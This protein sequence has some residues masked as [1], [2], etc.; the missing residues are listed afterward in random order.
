MGHAAYRLAGNFGPLIPAIKD[1]KN[2]GF[3]DV[4]WMLDDSIKELTTLNVF[5]V[6]QSRFGHLELLTPVD[7]K[8]LY[9]GVMRKSILDMSKQIEEMFNLKVVERNVSVHELVNSAREGRLLEMFGAATHCSLQPI[10]RVVYKD[11]TMVLDQ[12]T[13]GEITGK[14]SELMLNTMRGDDSHQWITPFE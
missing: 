12:F 14:L 4:L 9:N 5:V 10:S 2:N 13:H 7:D 3:D 6:Q 11:T 8:C 1:A